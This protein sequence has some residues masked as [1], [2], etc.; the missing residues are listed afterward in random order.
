MMIPKPIFFFQIPSLLFLGL[1]V[2]SGSLEAQQCNGSQQG[3][4]VCAVEASSR[5]D[6]LSV[7]SAVQQ[8]I[9]PGSS[10]ARAISSNDVLIDRNINSLM[11]VNVV[12]T[13]PLD[14]TQTQLAA[15]SSLERMNAQDTLNE[16]VGLWNSDGIAYKLVNPGGQVCTLNNFTGMSGECE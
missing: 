1:L 4:S 13:S 12:T 15:S 6:R 10:D 16:A 5:L 9:Q 14:K 3:G 11:E 8:S 2:S 7:Q